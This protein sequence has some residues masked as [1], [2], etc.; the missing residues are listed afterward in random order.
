[1]A[2]LRHLVVL[3]P[4]IGGSILTAPRTEAERVHYALTPAGVAGALARPGTLD[5]DRYP[6]LTPTGLVQDLTV[7]P[8]LL[9][10]PGYQRLILRLNNAFDRV[11]MDTY[12][13]PAP[14]HPRTDVLRFPYDFRQSIEATAQ[15]LDDAVAEALRH[16]G[17]AA[18]DRPVIIVAHSMGG[19]VARYWVAVLGGWRHCHAL[20]T[21]GT[22]VRGAPKALD[23]LV[24]GAGTG[25]L[26]DPRMT[27]VIR[28]WPS[29]YELLPQYEAV[30]DAGAGE[31]GAGKP[32]E[33]VELPPALL[34][35]RPTLADYAPRYAE[36]AA[37]GRAVHDRMRTAWAALDPSQVPQL[38]PFFGR[39]HGTPNLATLDGGRLRVTLDDPPWRGN[40]GWRGDGTV[41]MLA[42]VPPD[43]NDRQDLWR[44]RAERHGALGSIGALVEQLSLYAGERLPARG[45]PLPD[46]PWLG[47]DLDDL[48]PAGV[49]IPM[50]ARLLPD[51]LT[52]QAGWVTMTPMHGTPGEPHRDALTADHTTDPTTWRA[53]LPPRT[54]GWYEVATEVTGVPE[55]GSV[56]STT[57]L[58]VVDSTT[59]EEDG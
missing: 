40:V 18:A 4:G 6:E 52:G 47:L 39:G 50:A 48:A 49:E 35:G 5:L 33:L 2:R 42:A 27:R 56:A 29:M 46:R 16:R 38:V 23:W 19:L 45:G 36:M 59:E 57:T 15:R 10:L 21:A 9:T 3:L 13:P 43:L 20:V 24:N 34:A 7:L 12:R 55:Y 8:A 32:V 17:T 41:P 37:A 30:W 53:T 28:R 31:N 14:I 51:P 26:R 22:P 1:M 44:S 54:P 25:V 58:L 11:V